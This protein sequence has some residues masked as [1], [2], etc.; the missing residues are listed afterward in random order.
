M[1]DATFYN[2]DKQGRLLHILEMSAV[3]QANQDKEQ[4]AQRE[5]KRRQILDQLL[6]S[7]AKERLSRISLV[8]ADTVRQVEDLIIAMSAQH[9]LGGPISDAQLCQMLERASQG[10]NTE[11]KIAH[12]GKKYEDAWD[13]DDEGW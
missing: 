5:A 7:E 10:N 3:P 2:A 12:R 11:V 4:E 8:K 6:T 13:D 1:I 9:Q